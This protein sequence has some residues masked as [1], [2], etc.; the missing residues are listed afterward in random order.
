MLFIHNLFLFLY[1]F[2]F[3]CIFF[4]LTFHVFAFLWIFLYFIKLYYIT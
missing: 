3:D 1:L 2:R 4:Y